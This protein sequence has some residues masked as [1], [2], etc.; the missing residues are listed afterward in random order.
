[1]QLPSKKFNIIFKNT[2][3]VRC[4]HPGYFFRA[5][6]LFQ[7]SRLQLIEMIDELFADTVVICHHE[8]L[9]NKSFTLN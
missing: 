9:P 8:K 1:M 3:D 6:F 7:I 5:F 2:P 4:L